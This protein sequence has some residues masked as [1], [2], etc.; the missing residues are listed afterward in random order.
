MTAHIEDP[1][2]EKA[3]VILSVGEKGLAKWLRSKSVN[4][5]EDIVNLLKLRDS[6]AIEEY[7][8][9]MQRS[10]TIWRMC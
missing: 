9:F 1:E 8:S 10:Q 6:L 7:L 2:V 4:E 3:E 5:C